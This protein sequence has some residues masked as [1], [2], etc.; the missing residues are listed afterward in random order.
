MSIRAAVVAPGLAIALAQA[1]GAV[2]LDPSFGS[3]GIV[4]LYSEYS[5]LGPAVQGVVVQPDG[6]TV[7]AG[8]EDL[9]STVL[10]RLDW[11]GSLDDSFGS[12]G[13]VTGFPF[14]GTPAGVASVSGGKLLV[15][16]TNPELSSG[17]FVARLR[18]DGSLDT[19]FGAGGVSTLEFAGLHATA[20]SLTVAPDGRI[21][22]AGIAGSGVPPYN[23]SFAVA[24]FDSEG[25]PD[26]SFGSG[27]RVVVDIGGGYYAAARSIAVLPSG[28][29]LVSGQSDATPAWNCAIVALTNEGIPDP[30]FGM[31]GILFPEGVWD[32]PSLAPGPGS[33][34]LVGG[35]TLAGPLVFRMR[36]DGTLDDTFGG[37]GRAMLPNDIDPIN[38]MTT[39]G[40][41]RIALACGGASFI[42]A[43]LLPG[44]QPDRTLGPE[45]FARPVLGGGPPTITARPHAIA[46]APS[47]ATV[48]AGDFSTFG[49]NP[50]LLR[51][52]DVDTAAIPTLSEWGMLLLAALLALTGLVALGRAT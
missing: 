20:A 3:H 27:G 17:F 23:N 21:L 43:R 37:G 25:F 52:I 34:M 1:T 40:K 51:Y 2:T 14:A 26:G 35:R 29:I 46:I 7:T 13:K 16:G 38:A 49:V 19:S 48:L 47:G 10:L 15:A 6:K 45:G 8:V 41:G 12:G 11:N 36:E 33:T 24:R 5:N 18:G 44:G 42:F 4:I 31:A 50:A 30:T 22:I 9:N 39:D 32:C 28:K